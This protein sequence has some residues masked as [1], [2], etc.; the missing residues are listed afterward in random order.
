MTPSR[1]LLSASAASTSVPVS[2][3]SQKNAA[4]RPAGQ[5]LRWLLSFLIAILAFLLASFPARN[6]D[7]WLHLARGRLLAHGAFPADMAPD[8]AFNEWGNQT[9]LYDLFCYDGYRVLGGAGLVLAKAL[10]AAGIA[11]LLLRLSVSTDAS[12]SCPGWCVPAICTSLTLV[13]ISPYLLLQPATVSYLFLALVLTI[14]RPAARREHPAPLIYWPLVF[15]FFI[16]ANMDRWFLLGLGVVTLV[17]LGEVVD[18]VWAAGASPKRWLAVLLRRGF[19]LLVLAAACLLNPSHLYAFVLADEWAHIGTSAGQAISP[20]GSAYFAKAGWS[21]ASLSYFFLLGLSLLSFLAALPRWRWRRFLPWLGLALLSAGQ[22]RAVPFFALVAA[23]V[24]ACN[25]QDVL[26]RR[27]HPQRDTEL[28]ASM[29][30]L[31]QALTVMLVLALLVCAWPG[32]LLAPPFGPRR[33]A[34]DLPPSAAR[35][36]EIVRRWHEEGKLTADSGGLHLSADTVFA[37]AWFC[38]LDRRLRLTPG[39]SADQWRRMRSE[40][41]D[42]IFVYD[43]DRD[44]LSVTLRGLAADAKQCPLLFQEGDLAVFGW[45]DPERP[46]SAQRFRGWQV[47][48]NRLAFHPAKDKK[49]PTEASPPQ[50]ALRSWWDDF[51]KAASPRSLDRDEALMHLLHAE[52]LERLA[53]LRHLSDWENSQ[54]AGLIGAAGAWTSPNAALDAPLRLA[55]FRPHVPED[56]A[57]AA[58]PSPVDRMVM[59]LQRR[60]TWQRDDAP[61]AL[62]Y[63]A[64]RAA[65]RAVAAN[66]EDASAFLLLGES[67]LGLLHSTRE[68]AWSA[69]LPQ[70]MQLRQNQASAALYRAIALR[71]HFPQAHLHL[72]RL[73]QEMNYLD[74]ALVHWQSALRLARQSGPPTEA[75]RAAFQARQAQ[76][77]E[78]VKRLA[79]EVQKREDSVTLASANRPTRERAFLAFQKGLAGKALDVLL[80]SDRSAFGNE[81]MELELE[82][83]LGVGRAWDVQKWLNPEHESALGPS[84]HHW[85]RARALAA[86]GEYTR[87]EE[88]C[89]ESARAL[90]RGPNRAESVR[91]RENMALMIATLVLDGQRSPEAS[92]AN[93]LT[94][95]NQAALADQLQNLARLLKGQADLRVLHGLLA[96]EE[97][98]EE[99]AEFAFRAALEL[100]KDKTSAAAGGG[101]DFS[102]RI[103]AQSCLRWLE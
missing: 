73:Y 62:Y 23:P 99:E 60:Y 94:R 95:V 46:D 66:P 52:A 85:F 56:G 33:W 79:R 103:I 86:C 36:A 7:I 9:W 30:R 58:A 65:R 92:F 91:L 55:L 19:S 96:L 82:L 84:A 70:F 21:P 2:M 90:A 63:L 18:E 64:V 12:G 72:G 100:W 80:A 14:F 6:S 31:G 57:R 25:I 76:N 41:I 35:G 26:A 54:A 50:A 3:A 34:F 71:P 40:S 17:W 43:R 24:L 53:P 20:F 61:P 29:R 49:A 45:R 13:S 88:E 75:R 74:L 98:E 93:A 37:C 16:W 77:E 47:D 51:W 83:L 5:H 4:P 1:E 48:L 59:S 87:A 10:L 39:D 38:P 42:H 101:L 69:Q 22:A 44:R 15:L 27:F 89:A 8:L 68:R 32:W 97:G 81:G 11:L 102:G 67:Y 28:R 78:Q